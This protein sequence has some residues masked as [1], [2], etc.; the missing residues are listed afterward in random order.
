[1][2][3]PGHSQPTRP[4]VSTEMRPPP[5]QR[6]LKIWRL[7]W[8]VTDAQPHHFPNLLTLLIIGPGAAEL[9]ALPHRP[10][11]GV[12]RQLSQTEAR[13]L[14][15]PPPPPL[16]FESESG[17]L[18]CSKLEPVS[19]KIIETAASANPPS[20]RYIIRPELTTKKLRHWIALC[21]HN[22][23]AA[24]RSPLTFLPFF[25]LNAQLD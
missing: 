7:S 3:R 25:E 19:R 8:N 18:D 17:L 16:Q 14:L 2:S 23:S 6:I 11:S 4:A 12:I 5:S 22:P 10:V 15:I 13:H 1:V 21:T 9:P 24:L 20:Q